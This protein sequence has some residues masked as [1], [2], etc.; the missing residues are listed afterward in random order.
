MPRKITLDPFYRQK[1]YN[2][3]LLCWQPGTPPAY[4]TYLNPGTGMPLRIDNRRNPL[5]DPVIRAVD[6]EAAGM[7]TVEL[8]QEAGWFLGARG[9][10]S[11]SLLGGIPTIE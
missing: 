2:N 11:T 10:H 5:L 4:D 6:A 8:P 9:T 7:D 1:L 3:P